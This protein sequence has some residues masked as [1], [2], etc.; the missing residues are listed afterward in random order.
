MLVFHVSRNDLGMM[1][2]M[3]IFW[4]VYIIPI[5]V[6]YFM[7]NCIFWAFKELSVYD[8]ELY[9]PVS[10]HVSYLPQYEYCY[11]LGI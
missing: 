7:I 10:P 11:I 1:W 5:Y 3:E 9:H 2:I 6:D 8:R 4:L